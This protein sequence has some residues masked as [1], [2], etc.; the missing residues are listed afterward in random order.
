[1][2]RIH[3]GNSRTPCWFHLQQPVGPN[4]VLEIQGDVL[5][6]GSDK[7]FSFN[8][9][10]QPDLSEDVDLHF[11]PRP[12]KHEIALN[13]MTK[14]AWNTETSIKDRGIFEPGKSF[15][16]QIKGVDEGYEVSVHKIC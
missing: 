1:M 7:A 11:S 10:S 14:G 9:S 16:L 12:A 4:M 5:Q 3:S 8:L 13:T 2:P 6:P 15:I